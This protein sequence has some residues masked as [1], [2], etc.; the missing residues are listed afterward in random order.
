MAWDDPTA[1]HVILV[2][3]PGKDGKFSGSTYEAGSFD[4]DDVDQDIVWA[5]GF[6]IKWPEPQPGD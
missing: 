3:R 5:D 4:P 2:R 1:R 6:F